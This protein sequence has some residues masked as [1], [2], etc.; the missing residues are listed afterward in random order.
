MN[1]L[2]TLKQ[3]LK[4]LK[5]PDDFSS[6]LV[7]ILKQRKFEEFEIL[8]DKKIKELLQQVGVE[9]IDE[10]NDFFELMKEDISEKK[11]KIKEL[12]KERNKFEEWSY[13]W[14]EK[15]EERQRVFKELNKAI[16]EKKQYEELDKKIQY[17][18]KLKSNIQNIKNEITKNFQTQAKPKIKF[19]FKKIY[20]KTSSKN[21]SQEKNEEII[22]K[23]SFEEE[24]SKL[25]NKEKLNW[26]ISNKDKVSAKDWLKFLTKIDFTKLSESD[27]DKY[28]EL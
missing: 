14:T 7:E 27:Q 23:T 9:T 3:S 6:K 4:E 17:L 11:E 5:F 1:Y 8:L 15:E 24:F 13:D 25:T 18:L 20:K 10:F 12:V 2:N 26:I 28:L 16:K 19:D 21:I 22:K